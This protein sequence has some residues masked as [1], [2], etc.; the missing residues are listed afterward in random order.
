[1]TFI[2][3]KNIVKG[4]TLGDNVLPNDDNI[5]KGLLSYSFY[6]IA[7]KAES[8]H[9]MTLS[10]DGDIVRMASGD[11]VMRSPELPTSDADVLDIDH[12]LAYV[13]ARYLESLISKDKGVFHQQMGDQLILDYNHKVYQVQERVKSELDNLHPGGASCETI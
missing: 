11:Y 12:E 9:L 5:V 13:A 4:L 1:M 8:L 10:R 6:L 3:L 2:E 7:N